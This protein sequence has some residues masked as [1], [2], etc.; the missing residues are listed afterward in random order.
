MLFR[1]DHVD[2]HNSAMEDPFS[3]RQ[4]NW[5][6]VVD[7]ASSSGF[8]QKVVERVRA[9]CVEMFGVNSAASNTASNTASENSIL[10]RS[11]LRPEASLPDL[12]NWFLLRLYCPHNDCLKYQRKFKQQV[13]LL[14]HIRKHHG[15]DPICQ[16]PQQFVSPPDV[17]DW[18][19]KDLRCPA[20]HCMESEQVFPDMKLLREHV[21]A[22]HLWDP[23]ALPLP[24]KASSHHSDRRVESGKPYRLPVRANLNEMGLNETTTGDS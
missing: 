8:S 21:L 14:H 24:S 5:E 6:D 20:E 10:E 23:A 17:G 3:A 7:L 18:S 11:G 1:S 16:L 13:K 4:G 19:L 15:W 12:S 9:R 22:R 2:L